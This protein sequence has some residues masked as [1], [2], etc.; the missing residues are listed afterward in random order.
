M[1]CR[2]RGLVPRRR[3]RVL[4]L[5]ASLAAPSAVRAAAPSSPLPNIFHRP[6]SGRA[7]APSG[8]ADLTYHGGPVMTSFSAYLIFWRPPGVHYSSSVSD[9]NYEQLV[10]R[11]FQDVGGSPFYDIVTQYPGSNGTPSSAVTVGGTIVDT[12]PYP[13]AGTFADPLLDADIQQEI[14]TV[15]SAQGWPTGFGAMYF[16]FTG[17]GVQSCFD[18]L[19]TSCSQAQYCAYHFVFALPAGVVIYANMPDGFSFGDCGYA[20]VNGDPAADVVISTAS[21][22]HFEAVTDPLLNAWYR[23]DSSG[24]IGDLCAYSYGPA[25]SSSTPDVFLNGHPYALQSEW[26]NAP[27]ACALSLCGASVCA[28][29]LTLDATATSC[30]AGTGGDEID[31]AL[32]Y[33]NPSDVDAATDVSIVA[34]LPAGVQW[35]SGAVPTS[36]V[37]DVL[38]FAVPDVNVHGGGTLQFST[39]LTSPPAAFTLLPQTAALHYSDSL[40]EPVA[41]VDAS[42]ATAVPCGPWC[43]NGTVDAG[44]DCDDAG[45]AGTGC[46]SPT[47]QYEPSGSS[48]ASDGQACTT[49]VCDAMGTCT[50]Q[51]GNAG[52]VCRAAA[53]PCD[54]A[55][56]CDGV[57]TACPPNQS[58]PRS[59][60]AAGKSI[61]LAK[62]D[63]VGTDKLI[64]KWIQ[65]APTA[66]TEFGDPTDTADYALCIYAGAVPALVGEAAIPASASRW[67]VVGTK[68]YRYEDPSA[69]AGGIFKGLLKGSAANKSRVLVKGAGAPLPDLSL[70]IAAPVT[71]QLVNGANGLCWGASYSQILINGPARLKAQTP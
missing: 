44:E 69:A 39:T 1:T 3:W 48:C 14:A 17:A 27:S 15:I 57:S 23:N 46:C 10:T 30:V 45:A 7:A 5:A 42:A 55:E 63:G 11:Y 43:G 20:D 8:P 50:H 29:S 34:T 64:W 26:S 2:E 61:L 22:E 71:V 53:G 6:E 52:V 70:P 54:Q 35:A 37:G 13:R 36:V 28:P 12:H 60:R 4:L 21:H 47:C 18:S 24:E 49:D 25:W 59:C 68:G 31:Y 16:V 32:Q 56:Q 40:S 19:H 65:G 41:A 66:Q 67:S 51:A 9:A 38:T 33:D 62:N 58:A